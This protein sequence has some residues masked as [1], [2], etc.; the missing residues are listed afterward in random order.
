MLPLVLAPL[1]PD[2]PPWDRA[3]ASEALARPCPLVS[4][5][6]LMP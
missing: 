2:P 4:G 3:P 6:V 5:E 1:T